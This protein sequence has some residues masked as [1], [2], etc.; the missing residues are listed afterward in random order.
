[1]LG[2]LWKYRLVLDWLS[3]RKK[4]KRNKTMILDKLELRREPFCK[5]AKIS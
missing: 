4:W 3:E 2:I 1:M 5:A